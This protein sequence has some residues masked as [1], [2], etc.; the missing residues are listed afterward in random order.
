MTVVD[1]YQYGYNFLF[2]RI[3]NVAYLP[4]I[5]TSPTKMDVVLEILLQ[6]K[7]KAQ[8]LGLKAADIVFDQAIYAKAIEALLNPTYTFLFISNSIFMVRAEVAKALKRNFG[9]STYTPP[10]FIL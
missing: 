2:D 3:Y 1:A 7:E 5:D 8:K 10:N 6:S 4:A 9:K